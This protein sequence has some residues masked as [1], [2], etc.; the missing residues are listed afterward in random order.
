M[1][2]GGTLYRATCV[3]GE[4]VMRM[5]QS[6]THHE[7]MLARLGVEGGGLALGSMAWESGGTC[8]HAQEPRQA[9]TGKKHGL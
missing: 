9:Y 7:D 5:G 4:R 6:E 8:G 3:L 2:E 1:N